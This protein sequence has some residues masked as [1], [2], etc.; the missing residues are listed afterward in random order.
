MVLEFRKL[1]DHTV[2]VKKGTSVVRMSMPLATRLWM[3]QRHAPHKK[4]LAVGPFVVLSYAFPN[5]IKGPAPFC[6][7]F[8]SGCN[9]ATPPPWPKEWNPNTPPTWNQIPLGQWVSLPMESGN[10][11]KLASTS[12]AKREQAIQSDIQTRCAEVSQHGENESFME[13]LDYYTTLRV[14]RAY[15]CLNIQGLKGRLTEV[16]KRID[17][18]SAVVLA[19][20]LTVSDGWMTPNPADTPNID[21]DDPNALCAPQN[22]DYDLLHV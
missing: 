15:L 17:E 13:S 4:Q 8:Q 16:Q 6:V 2:T 9:D 19:V 11:M 1:P 5:K 3:Q 21:V 7:C 22:E 10:A 12:I 14:K 18:L 20:P